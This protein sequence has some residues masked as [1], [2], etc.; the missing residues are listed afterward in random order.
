[1]DE[2]SWTVA[3]WVGERSR[4]NWSSVRVRFGEGRCDYGVRASRVGSVVVRIGEDEETSGR[5]L[6][7]M[8]GR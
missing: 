3:N 5:M 2:R 7:R 8:G 4:A 1:M 6:F